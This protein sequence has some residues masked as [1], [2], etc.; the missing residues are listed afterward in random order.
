MNSLKRRKYILSFLC[1]LAGL[2]IFNNWILGFALNPPALI[3]GAT[4]SELS[5]RSQPHA[6]VFRILDL[7]AALLLIVSVDAFRLLG[8]NR[9][10]KIFLTLGILIVSIGN[11]LDA[12]IPLDCSAVLERSCAVHEQ[13]G[14]V[15]T[16]HTWHDILSPIIYIL[17]FLLPYT[18]YTACKERGSNPILR[19]TSALLMI[20]M[21]AWGAITAYRI[22]T[23]SQTFGYEQVAF[24]IAFSL[25]FI[26]ALTAAFQLKQP[27]TDH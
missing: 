14:L 2:A 22:K 8:N 15:S 5:A 25:W 4:I 11:I 10:Q 3:N 27:D 23:G 16:L 19:K 9:K 13:Y 7:F 18:A 20:I 12:F 1:G 6:T 24:T 21:I 26:F 17:L